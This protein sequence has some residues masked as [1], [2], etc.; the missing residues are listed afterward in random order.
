MEVINIPYTGYTGTDSIS[1]ASSAVELTSTAWTSSYVTCTFP[2]ISWNQYIDGSI[3]IPKRE[4]TCKCAYCECTNDHIYG[5][6]DYCGAPLS[7]GDSG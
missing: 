4:P 7:G 3:D 5:T 6:C 2:T 1:S